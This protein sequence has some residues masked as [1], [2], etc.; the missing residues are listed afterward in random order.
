MKLKE[1][2]RSIIREEVQNVLKEDAKSDIMSKL[3]RTP[4][5]KKYEMTFDIPGW[6][7][8]NKMKIGTT[9]DGRKT[10]TITIG[11]NNVP[12]FDWAERKSAQAV[13]KYFPEYTVVNKGGTYS[14]G[15]ADTA[16]AEL[17]FITKA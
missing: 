15:P 6:V 10:Y 13:Q 5:W 2:L 12:S 14:S 16:T 11:F 17:T 3:Q 8:P 4:I 9:K 7:R 1:T